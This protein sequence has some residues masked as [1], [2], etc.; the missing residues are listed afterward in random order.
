M[1]DFWKHL[2]CVRDK[3]RLEVRSLLEFGMQLPK[4]SDSGDT[5]QKSPSPEVSLAGNKKALSEL[6]S[7]GF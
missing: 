5:R 6:Y 1:S 3:T 2:T 7:Q 4:V